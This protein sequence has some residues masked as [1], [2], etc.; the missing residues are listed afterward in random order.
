NHLKQIKDFYKSI[1]EDNT[2]TISFETIYVDNCSSDGSVDFLKQY[3]PQVKILINDTPK[4]FGENNNI[5]T[6]A[7]SGK[8]L[9]LFNPDIVVQKGCIDN[10]YNYAEKHKEIGILAPKLLDADGSL[11][12]SVRGFLSPKILLW[13]LMT[14]GKDSKEIEAVNDYL[15]KYMD[16]T[17]IQPVNWSSGAAFFISRNVYT[18][19]AGFDTG[20]FLYMEDEDICLR[21]W[22]KGFPVIYF[23]EAKL[24][25][26]SHRESLKF[27]KKSLVHLK[28]VLTFFRKHGFSIPDYAKDY[29]VKIQNKENEA[30]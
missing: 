3:Y 8:Y 1:Y 24:V 17:K 27:G 19:L 13:R 14:K 9:A 29:S 11:Q 12:Y 10:L 16:H 18:K 5:G 7:S 6:S 28:S 26:D 15:C 23:P 25:H 2:P 21:A 20:F 22:E 30:L 4:G